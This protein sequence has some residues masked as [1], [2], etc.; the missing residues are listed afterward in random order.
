MRNA[1]WDSLSSVL[2]YY[3]SLLFIEPFNVLPNT[4]DHTNLLNHAITRI[5]YLNGSLGSHLT[6]DSLIFIG[7]KREQDGL[8]YLT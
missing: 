3:T 4:H 8:N 2:I 1:V 5:L 7:E 6:S